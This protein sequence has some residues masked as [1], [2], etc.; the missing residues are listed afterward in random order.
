MDLTQTE[1]MTNSNSSNIDWRELGEEMDGKG[2]KGSFACICC[3]AVVYAAVS[4][5]FCLEPMQIVL[6]SYPIIPSQQSWRPI[7]VVCSLDPT[8]SPLAIGRK[9]RGTRHNNTS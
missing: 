8:R 2:R 7:G 6:I 9:C 4:M 3:D 5:T 1:D